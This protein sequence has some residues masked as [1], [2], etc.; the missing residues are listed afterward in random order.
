[1]PIFILSYFELT[2]KTYIFLKASFFTFFA[3]FYKCLALVCFFFLYYNIYE[4][5]YQKLDLN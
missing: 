3:L 5:N 1:M 2:A 4:K